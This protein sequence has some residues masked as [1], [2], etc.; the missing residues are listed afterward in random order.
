MISSGIK[1][2][3]TWKTWKEQQKGAQQKKSEAKRN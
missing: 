3:P 1:K 2:T